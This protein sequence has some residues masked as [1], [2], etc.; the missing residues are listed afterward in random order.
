M[1]AAD[2]DNDGDL[3]IIVNNLNGPPGL[4]RNDSPAPRVSVRLKGAAPNTR[5]IGAKVKVLGGAVPMQSQEIICGG[6]YL[7]SDDPMRMF[8]VGN[9]DMTIEVAWRNGRKSFVQGARGNRIYEID[10]SSSIKAAAEKKFVPPPIFEDV[11]AAIDYRHHDEPFDDWSSQPLLSRKLSQLGPGAAW[12]D[13]NYDGRE[14]LIIGAGRGG[15][16]G[17]F[18]NE[19]GGKFG[20]FTSASIGAATDDQTGIVGWNGS[21][22][23]GVANYETKQTNV[24][25]QRFQST[26]AISA[27]ETL[28]AWDASAGPLVAADFDGD[29]ALDLFIGGRVAAG[30]YPQ[31][32]TSRI[33]LNRN[34]RWDLA[35]ELDAVGLVSGAVATDLDGDGFPE[36]VLACDWGPVRVFKN[37]R[38]H[39]TEITASLVLDKFTG[40][41]NSVTA[42]DFDGDGRMDFIAGNWGEN[43]KYARPAK[44]NLC[45]RF[46]DFDGRPDMLETCIDPVLKTSVPLRGMDSIARALPSIKERFPSYSAFS[47]ASADDILAGRRTKE[48]SVQ[49]LQ[50]MVFLNRGDHFDAIPLPL[51]AQF[52]PVFGMSVAD[53][54]SDGA[55][56]ILLSQNFFGVDEET[57]RYDAGRGLLLRGDGHGHFTS[58]PGQESGIL[59]YGEGRGVAVCDYDQDGRVDV[60]M[61][62]NSNQ[63]K[64]FHNVRGKPGLRVKLEG[65]PLNPNAAGAAIRMVYRD[66]LGP[67]REIHAGSGYWSQDS[68]T[69]VLARNEGATGIWIRWSGGKTMTIPLPTATAG[70]TLIVSQSGQIRFE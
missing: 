38:G 30:R 9:G 1:C 65:P 56:D 17:I 49:T 5:G 10:E 22:T 50:S 53:I 28:P 69:Q 29:G 42:G 31:P 11:S 15:Q 67:V 33:Y 70:N 7:S 52:S 60:V 19:G 57:S 20:R 66:H 51:E 41:W 40:W 43:T 35:Q 27:K 47:V 46:G 64:L 16:I 54:D 2:L 63:A 3:D 32:V 55:E 26:V 37:D 48:L 6:R 23:V 13:L 34:G 39:F 62:Q 45:A 61:T 21:F 14:D 25:A 18:I 59:V 68:A 8:A 24:A 12:V 36:L 58:V 44:M 4:Y